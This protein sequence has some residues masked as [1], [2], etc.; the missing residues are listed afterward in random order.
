[1]TEKEYICYALENYRAPIFSN[2]EFNSD[3]H[4]VYMIK[5]MFIRYNKTKLI[6]ERLLLN[7]IILVINQFGVQAANVILFL[8]INKESHCA[9]KTF[10]VYLNAYNKNKYNLFVNDTDIFITN[11]LKDITCKLCLN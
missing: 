11:K 3:L 6:N 7:N 9:L 10:L 1:M 5:K 8:K 2:N 4:Q